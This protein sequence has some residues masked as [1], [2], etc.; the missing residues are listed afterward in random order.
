MRL[1]MERNKT[2]KNSKNLFSYKTLADF[3]RV[4]PI[5]KSLPRL[6]ARN[7]VTNGAQN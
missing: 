2:S 5:D 7:T 1:F 6:M 3:F 4:L